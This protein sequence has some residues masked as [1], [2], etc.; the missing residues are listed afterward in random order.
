[1]QEQYVNII[2]KMITESTHFI[3]RKVSS[4]LFVALDILKSHP[5]YSAA[6]G[7]DRTICLYGR[8]GQNKRELVF[9]VANQIGYKHLKTV[10]MIDTNGDVYGLVERLTPF[11]DNKETEIILLSNFDVYCTRVT[12]INAIHALELVQKMIEHENKILVI[13]LNA[14]PDIMDRRLRNLLPLMYYVHPPTEKEIYHIFTSLLNDMLTILS[15]QVDLFEWKITASDIEYLVDCSLG[16]SVE[17]ISSFTE[18]MFKYLFKTINYYHSGPD[19][20]VVDRAF[21]DTILFSTDSNSASI[22]PTPPHAL[23]KRFSTYAR[24]IYMNPEKTL[25]KKQLMQRVFKSSSSGETPKR[26]FIDDDLIV[27]DESNKKKKAETK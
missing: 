23:N 1:M 17:D 4:S 11:I 16:C 15:K 18:M 24:E 6:Y 3:D 8:K 22:V 13:L 9:A 20:F 26:K 21:L 7:A 10:D 14:V 5:E 19:K 2:D 12:P 25:N 27:S